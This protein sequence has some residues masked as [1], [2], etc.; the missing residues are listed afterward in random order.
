MTAKAQSSVWNNLR[1]ICAAIAV[2]AM[3]GCAT[4]SVPDA[5]K[6]TRIPIAVPC[7]TPDQVP[8]RPAFVTDADLARKTDDQFVLSL[9][10][11]RLAR[12]EYE[13]KLE[14]R[15][16]GCVSTKPLPGVIVPPATVKPDTARPWWKLW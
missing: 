3:G 14:A 16:A 7:L 10:G 11:D 15:I 8:E 1:I 4:S 6:E 9:A 13:G 12:M 5:P 2:F